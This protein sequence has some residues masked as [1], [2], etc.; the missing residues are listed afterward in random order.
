M[1]SQFSDVAYAE[2]EVPQ[3]ADSVLKLFC[4]IVDST[5][6]APAVSW[7]DVDTSYRALDELSS[8]VANA[9]IANGAV[10]GSIVVILLDNPVDQIVATLGCLKAGCV[11]ASLDVS[12]PAK[13]LLHM[14]EIVRAEWV[15]LE[16]STHA[17]FSALLKDGAGAAPHVLVMGQERVCGEGA[18]VHR[19]AEQSTDRTLLPT[20]PDD[21]CYIYFTSG[22]TGKPK[23]IVGRIRGLAHFIQWEMAAFSLGPESRISQLTG[24]A[25]DVYL[26]DV[27]AA[28]CSGGTVCIP[29]AVKLLDPALLARW[30]E[31]A[32]ITQI[33]CVPSVFRLLLRPGLTP[34]KFP[35]L[36]FV[37][38]AGESLPLA[39][40]NAWIA[41]FGERIRLVNL[42][43]PTETTLAKFFYRL[44]AAPIAGTFVPVGRPI[45]GAQAVLLDECLAPCEQGQVGEIFIRTPYRSLGYYRDTASTESA[46]IRNPFAAD[47]SD[48][49]Y[50]TGDLGEV[51]PDGNFRFAGR[52]DFQVKIGG[53]RIELGEIEARL[54]EHPGVSEV[55]VLAREDHPGD[56]R[57]VAYYVP[58]ASASESAAVS[59]PELRR[60]LA[61]LLPPYMVPALYVML[62]SFPLSVNG[63]L[64]RS[65]L[66]APG[67]SRP[68]QAVAYAPPI[69]GDEQR[70]C[71]AFA[72][73]LGIERVGRNDNFFELGG[74][75]LLVMSLLTRVQ[76]GT[77]SAIPAA[78]IFG[79]PTPASLAVALAQDVGSTI[80]SHRLSHV[81]R[82][83]VD[84]L[85]AADDALAKEP[86]AIV[87]MAGRFPGASDVE[88]FWDNLCAGR[89]SI[90]VF[91]P[92]QLD[93]SIAAS[94]RLDPAYV[95]AR[96]VIDG[97]E[98][99]DA[100]FFGISPREAELM[101]PQHRI[102]LEL[103]W[104]C[105]ERG[106]HVPDT[107]TVPVGVFAGTY[108]ATYL[109]RHV[110]AHPDLVE[111]VGP[112]Q[113]I[114]DNEKDYIATRIA[115]KL[116]LTGPAISMYTACSTSLVAICQAL[117][118]LRAGSCDMALA[119]GSSIICPPRSGQRYQEGAMFSPDGHTR[120]FDAQAQGTAFSDGA[121]V[122]LL[123]RL[124]D[125][126]RDGNPVHAL[127]LG[128]AVNN[129][130]G[131]KASFTAPSS[132]GQA[133]VIAMAQ[134]NAR[135]SPRSISYVEAHGTATPLG[136][137][138]EIEG[139]VKAFRRGTSD[140]GFCRIGSVKSNVGHLV[141]AAGAAGVIKTALALA[142]EKIPASLHFKQANPVIDFSSSPF[143][144]NGELSEWTSDDAPRRAGVSSFGVGG[145][146]AHVVL[147][148]APPLPESEAGQG[149]N[150]LVLSARSPTVLARATEN[151][152]AFL[153]A[154]L[155]RAE[156]EVASGSPAT[157]VL[158]LAD[159][160]WTLAVGRKAFPH[161]VAVVATQA[162]EA[163]SQLRSPELAAAIKRG[164][165]ARHCDVIFTFPGQG[166]HYAGMGRALY[167]TEPAFA[168]AFDQ[169]D[170][171]LRGEPGL[172]LRGSVFSDN[173]AVLLPTAVM[174]PAIFSI[175]YALARLW[176]S[177]GLNPVAMIGHSIGEFVAATI[178]GVF[179]LPDALR[180]IARRGALMQ[181][182]PAGGMLS[183]RLALEALLQRL[184][185]GLS[186]AAENAPG[187]CVVAGPIER[188]AEFQMQL[189]ADGVTCRA[190][191]TS[192][193]FHSAMMEP[194]VGPFRDAV[195]VVARSAPLLP[196]VSTVTGDW[197]DADSA[198]SS[199]YWSRHLR[200]P[201]RFAAALE[202][203]VA[204]APSRVLLEVGPRA[205]LTLLS[206]Q[207]PAVQKALVV[208]VPSLADAPEL[209]AASLR[210]AAGQLWCRGVEIEVA[211]F[212]RRGKRMR[213]RLP[214]YPFERQRC[215]VEAAATSNI[216]RLPA[217]PATALHVVDATSDTPVDAAAV[218]SDRSTRL[219]AQ[220][221]VMFGDI[222]GFDMA[223]ADAAANF[224]ELGLDSLM[225]TQIALQLQ[226]VFAVPVTFRQLM[227]ECTSLERLSCM[228][229]ERLPA[230]PVVTPVAL[231]SEATVVSVEPA[232]PTPA[233]GM[234]AGAVDKAILCQMLEQQMQLLAQQLVLLR[235]SGGVDA[236]PGQAFAA[237][238]AQADAAVVSTAAAAA[239]A[240]L[241]VAKARALMDAALPLVP[242]ARIGR[243]P[244]GQPA[245]FVP[246]PDQ[247]GRYLKLGT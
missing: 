76:E 42:Y 94:D 79:N 112:Y 191:R 128:G 84:R 131:G 193:A 80:Q 144:V 145:T 226:K 230:K 92:D 214:T 224:M 26:R 136:D 87:A 163:I 129:D 204:D 124:S 46:F 1:A 15:I 213:V 130:G 101:D 117:D 66:P 91:R 88:Q 32:R 134:A 37:L 49:L 209:E 186:L 121:A 51:L 12:Y 8:Q 125:A 247:P 65:A 235:G 33:H 98:N 182:Q 137:P 138:I 201:V 23:A 41:C 222:T 228:L 43:G 241:P 188:I 157:K 236:S 133:A 158:N 205:T 211:Q 142:R 239:A 215:W 199:D 172:D 9:L 173:P 56:T 34:E 161:R 212:D 36:K 176:M 78:M 162:Q 25:F 195:E 70:L 115:H 240:L 2:L 151:L 153:Q 200:Q 57:L 28:L 187:T 174:Q 21:P 218:G 231:E 90:T 208:A 83:A 233:P 135:V 127:I 147:E 20:L 82:S 73:V 154:D 7:K 217:M 96:G 35:A 10:Q 202:R 45:P 105:M 52:K 229:D 29:P 19:V 89:D 126:I 114:L 75:S 104:E 155:D 180:L 99:F 238:V 3:Q 50:R 102:F 132:E 111:K 225:L 97:V 48:L 206:R 183:V 108:H 11:F 16:A 68:E 181:A 72:A 167:E 165:P 185:E 141:I 120:T 159:V 110:F 203:A 5:P 184:P 223:A 242:G 18:R 13:R 198:I 31:Q 107:T 69:D 44:P 61:D 216:V 175:E 196:I 27:F 4:G 149:P 246:N 77:A 55:A 139:L 189:E 86:I 14:L 106:G 190:L 71:E 39:D 164:G 81:H 93:P 150:L 122:V 103:C 74:S 178:A 177:R 166:S 197:L 146:N 219:L 220:L 169:C 62:E 152:A 237:S 119:G 243:E 53:N 245:W 143:V 244:D 192:H 38:L 227:S 30:I 109:R 116:N 168:A 40:A 140:V 24:P 47:T 67:S 221:R 17:R 85:A 58:R 95:S 156:S 148:Q 59:T 6:S 113:V 123:K 207:H 63:K 179:A 210:G 171:V 194:V 60:H 160:A 54:R 232:P 64:D 100:G 22:S 170:E 234:P 118:S